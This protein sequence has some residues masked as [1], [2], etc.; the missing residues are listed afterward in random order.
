LFWVLVPAAALAELNLD[1]RFGE[2]KGWK[3]GFSEAVDGC[4]AS[5][6]Y[7]DQTTVWIGFSGPDAYIAFTN[8]R[9]RSIQPKGG[10]ELRLR[11]SRGSWKGKFVGFERKDEKGIFASGLK[12]AFIDEL[13]GSIGIRVYINGQIVSQP[14]LSGSHDAIGRV[15]AC[16]K[17]YREASLPP[18]SSDRA[19]SNKGEKSSGTGFFVT[20]EGHILTNSHVLRGCTRT[21]IISAG[22]VTTSGRVVA[23]DSTNDLAILVSSVKPAVVPAFRSSARLG[24]N[25][26][27]FGFPLTGILSS[28]GNYTT[29]SVTAL[30]GLSDDS[31]MLQIS[32]PVQQGNSGGPLIDKYGN[33][34]GV[35]VSKLNALMFASVLKDIRQNVNFA[36]KA[37]VA[38]NFLISNGLRP[39]ESP[40]TRELPPEATA[41]L[42]KLFTVRILCE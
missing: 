30:T 17:E 36:I 19:D 24:E 27:V 38:T 25:I 2:V 35:V 32:A 23:N 11:T 26:S 42:A 31:R 9:W 22:S 8:P 6:T 34:T 41:E 7:K 28:S 18:E 33:V 40:K 10:Y 15:L 12:P 13:I 3:I 5:A 37:N 29:G 1:K 4:V 20:E 16:Q 14:S 39:N 21:T